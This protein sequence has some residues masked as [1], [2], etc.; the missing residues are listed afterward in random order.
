[1]SINLYKRIEVSENSVNILKTQIFDDCLIN[2]YQ[3]NAYMGDYIP[4]SGIFVV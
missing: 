3:K 2:E 1:M 4:V